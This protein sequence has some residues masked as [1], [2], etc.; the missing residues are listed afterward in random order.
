VGGGASG[1]LT[2]AHLIR[3]ANG[4]T[5]V[6]LV[7]RSDRVGRGVAYGTDNPAH[8]LNVPAGKMSAWPDE[9]DDFVTWVGR[10]HS[11]FL[12]AHADPARAFLPRI[13]YGEY[14]ETVLKQS[15]G[16]SAPDVRLE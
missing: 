9:P 7:E 15:E 14:L 11:S 4:P 16:G 2:A 13:I 10:T 5:R 1:V 6:L 3:H 12:T 8:L